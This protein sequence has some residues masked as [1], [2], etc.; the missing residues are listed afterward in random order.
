MQVSLN[1]MRIIEAVII[2]GISA[3][4]SMYAS[5]MVMDTKLHYIS[6][7]TLELKN[8][9]REMRDA[10]YQCRIELQTMRELKR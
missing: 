3:V 5:Q 8:E 4:G 6:E 7:V 10:V 1:M 9:M 2:A